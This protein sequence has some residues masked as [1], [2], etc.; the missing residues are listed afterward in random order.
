ML[1]YL[2]SNG[3]PVQAERTDFLALATAFENTE[4]RV[5]ASTRRGAV[6][7][8]TVFL[9]MGDAPLLWETMILGGPLDGHQERAASMEMAILQHLDAKMEAFPRNPP[10]TR[11]GTLPGLNPDGTVGP[12]RVE[13]ILKPSVWDRLLRDEALV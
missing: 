12:R 3:E 10:T 1:Y 4:N 7:V 9:M 6:H 2:N 11:W 5:V 8:S 13:D